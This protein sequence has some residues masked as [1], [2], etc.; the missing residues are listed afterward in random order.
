MKFKK[1]LFAALFA[2]GALAPAF[3]QQYPEKLVTIVV[4]FPPGGGIDVMIRAVAAE[5][6]SRWGK[7]VIIENKGGAGTLIGAEAV[8]RAKPDGHTLLA[9]IDQ[10]IVSNRFLYKSLPYDPD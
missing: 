8:A 4:P 6:S 10:T 7:P 2:L 5:L 9:T 1:H 3:A